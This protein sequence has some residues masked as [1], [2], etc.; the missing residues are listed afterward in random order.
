MDQ[1]NQRPQL[2]S[3]AL[4]ADAPNLTVH[5]FL[6]GSDE[7]YARLSLKKYQIFPFDGIYGKPG[8]SFADVDYFFRNDEI[9]SWRL[10]DVELPLVMVLNLGEKM[11]KYCLGQRDP[12][13]VI[14]K[15]VGSADGA[16][17]LKDVAK[18]LEALK[19]M[20]LEA[21]KLQTRLVED[22]RA[23]RKLSPLSPGANV[24]AKSVE[25]FYAPKQ[26]QRPRTA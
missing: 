9:V 24:I 5:D 16:I 14:N 6:L 3:R 4:L 18:D 7:K 23:A 12:E 19:A 1:E 15:D 21:K 8:K 2:P 22:I 25:A 11:G 10:K 20:V 17:D 13:I 26:V